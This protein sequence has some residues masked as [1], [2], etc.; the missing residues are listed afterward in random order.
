MQFEM[1]MSMIKQHPYLVRKKCPSP[2]TSY[3]KINVGKDSF[4]YW[5]SGVVSLKQDDEKCFHHLEV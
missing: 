3:G 1:D 2:R 5:V 4:D